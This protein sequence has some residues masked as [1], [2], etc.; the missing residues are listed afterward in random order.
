MKNE[1]GEWVIC[2]VRG[3]LAG[4]QPV[5]PGLR[6]GGLVE[7]RSPAIKAGDMVVTAGAAA[8]PQKTAIRILKD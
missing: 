6:D 8:L 1:G 2:L 4:Q 7:V 3:K 5:V